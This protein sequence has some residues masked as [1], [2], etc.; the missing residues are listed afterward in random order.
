MS[1]G[2]GEGKTQKEKK[3]N[4]LVQVCGASQARLRVGY[5]Q[6]E[7]EAARAAAAPGWSGDIAWDEAVMVAMGKPPQ[8]GETQQDQEARVLKS[9]LEADIVPDSKIIKVYCAE[10]TL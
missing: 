10:G 1:I 6:E 4:L 5:F 3:E 2:S 9:V 8:Q 7:S